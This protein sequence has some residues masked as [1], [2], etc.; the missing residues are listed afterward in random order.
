MIEAA[1]VDEWDH[2]LGGSLDDAGTP[3]R[4]RGDRGVAGQAVAAGADLGD[5]DRAE[6]GGIGLAERAGCVAGFADPFGLGGGEVV[7]KAVAGDLVHQMQPVERV[8]GEGDAATAVGADAI[9]LD[10]VAG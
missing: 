7:V 3:E 4:W 9:I 1:L 10:V 2:G 6:G 5:I 8:A